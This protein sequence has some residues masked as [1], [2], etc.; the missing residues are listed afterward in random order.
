MSSNYV[1]IYTN[2]EA[3][4]LKTFQYLTERIRAQDHTCRK[5]E[6]HLACN[7][8]MPSYKFARKPAVMSLH[9]PPK[10]GGNKPKVFFGSPMNQPK[11]ALSLP[12][13]CPRPKQN[14]A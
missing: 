11:H 3:C 6:I 12:G 14:I 4:L 1:K 2:L 10:V 5:H 9:L 8:A 7:F 13:K